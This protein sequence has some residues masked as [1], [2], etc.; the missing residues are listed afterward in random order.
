[1]CSG[2]A[3]SLSG[4]SKMHL[5]MGKEVFSLEL[6]SH[7]GQC[8]HGLCHVLRVFFTYLGRGTGEVGNRGGWMG[9]KEVPVGLC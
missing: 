6:V 2:G 9:R 4:S 7:L 1:M 8:K 3:F 5:H